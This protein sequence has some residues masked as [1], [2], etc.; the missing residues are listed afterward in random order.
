MF[1]LFFLFIIFSIAILQY[2]LR[3]LYTYRI[4][5][6]EVQV[7]LFGFFPIRRLSLNKIKNAKVLTP[8]E[9]LHNYFSTVMFKCE[10]WGNRFWGKVIL[11]EKK[12]G[13]IIFFLISPDD[14]EGM[15]KIINTQIGK[16]LEETTT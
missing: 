12:S 8:K 6:N 3:F 15:A 13:I 1:F 4:F 11:I 7:V 14:A 16:S 10:R 5:N 9:L 2:G